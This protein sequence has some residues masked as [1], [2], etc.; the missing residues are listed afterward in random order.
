MKLLPL[1]DYIRSLH[2]EAGLSP[3]L[4]LRLYQEC[5]TFVTEL[6]VKEKVNT[7]IM[8]T[9]LTLLH[10][11]LK[12]VA[13]TEIDRFLLGTA[14]VY[15][16]C[17]IDYRHLSLEKVAE[18]YFQERS[19]G[20]KSRKPLQEIIDALF[21]EYCRLEISILTSI[22]FDLEFDLPVKHARRF[23]LKYTKHV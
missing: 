20:K 18:F 8:G 4:E 1:P 13:F 12:R 10:Y 23:K 6:C 11:Y 7:E 16:A 21:Q 22:E 3:D 9:A 14:C 5:L 17:K 15:L 19:G 2:I